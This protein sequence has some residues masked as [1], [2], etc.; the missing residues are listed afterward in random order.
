MEKGSDVCKESTYKVFGFEIWFSKKVTEDDIVRRYIVGGINC[1]L[2]S[3]NCIPDFKEYAGHPTQKPLM[4]C[5]RIVRAS[6]QVGG[7]VMVPFAGSG[8]EVVVCIRLGRHFLT[9]ENCETYYHDILSPR[10]DMACLES[11]EGGQRYICA[12]MLFG[13]RQL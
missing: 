3:L 2:I 7:M 1:T 4:L 13:C 10:S 8:S 11:V 9:N 6:S 5:E 12:G